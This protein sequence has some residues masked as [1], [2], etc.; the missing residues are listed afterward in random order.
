MSDDD[1]T[2]S[3]EDIRELLCAAPADQLDASMF[4][5]I[6]RWDPEP[7][8]LQVL[9]V[10]DACIHGALASSFTIK[11][12]EI[13]YEVACK[14]EGVTHEQAAMQASWR[15]PKEDTRA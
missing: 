10:L 14:R 15:H 13:L 4:P 5:L 1:A 3:T 7:S 2:S 6:M 12:L 8:A 9:E 11:T